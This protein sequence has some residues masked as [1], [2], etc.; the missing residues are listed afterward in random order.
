MV[1]EW[2]DV[3]VDSPGAPVLPVG[4]PP[5]DAMVLVVESEKTITMKIKTVNDT[6]TT[7]FTI[8]FVNRSLFFNF[9][10]PILLTP[11]GT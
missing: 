4:A 7:S 3:Q 11:S 5:L 10:L 9:I 8:S 6:I 2:H 1:C